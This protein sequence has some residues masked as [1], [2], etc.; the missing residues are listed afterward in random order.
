MIS[1][2]IPCY[3]DQ[4]VLPRAVRSALRQR[5]RGKLEVVI[6]DD[7]SK[8]PVRNDF[9]DARVRLV[10]HDT[11]L[12]LSNAINTGVANA[13]GDRFVVLAS[14]DELAPEYLSKV[15]NFDADI[16]SC[17][18]LSGGR[19]VR[20]GAPPSLEALMERNYHSYAALIKRRVWEATGGFKAAMNPS[21]EDWEFFLNAYKTGARW[22]HVSE[23]LHIY[24]RNQ[25]GRDAMAQGKDKLL[26]GKLMGYHQDIYGLGRGVVAFVIP[27]YRHEAY[28]A[29][30]AR[31]ALGQVYPHVRVVV[32]DDGSPGD[33]QGALSDIEDDRLVLIRQE[34]RHLSGARNSGITYA[35]QTWNPEY[36]VMLDADDMVHSDYLEV[37]LGAYRDH[38]YIYTDVEFRG[39]A[40]H[41]VDMEEYDCTRLA[42]KHLH[43]CTFLQPAQMWRDI[44]AA[45]GYGYD[46]YMKQGYEDWEYAIAALST[47]W[48]GRRVP[49]YYF[50]YRYHAGGSMRTEA[51]KV[52]DALVNYI[53]KQHPWLTNKEYI[54]A[55]C[56]SCG[57]GHGR[58][59][60]SSSV[61]GGGSV[62]INGV[63][64]VA[65]GEIL[66]VTYN[67][68]KTSTMQKIGAGGQIYRYSADPTKQAKGYGPRFTIYARDAHLFVGQFTIR[69]LSASPTIGSEQQPPV[70][71]SRPVEVVEIRPAKVPEQKTAQQIADAKPKKL[72]EM[73]V[74][75]ALE[76][77]DA[78]TE[79]PP[80]DFSVLRGVGRAGHDKLVRAGFTVYDD[81]AE[82]SSTEL[83][84]ILGVD[85]KKAESIKRAAAKMIEE[86]S[87][88][89]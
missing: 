83:A 88:G 82:A 60:T 89:E 69:R 85:V 1:I 81:V 77:T 6:V 38:E 46:E 41:R 3:N 34:N 53:N 9:G 50:Y 65:P 63:G 29:D 66:Q 4:D 42:K 22:V 49:G 68:S 84:A 76:L 72:D 80:E 52:R 28:V 75:E 32:V 16:V 62:Y 37:T 67:G 21:W 87:E 2:I 70:Q 56:R 19:H 64:E 5:Y 35:L 8:E 78:G 45:R 23:P 55:A 36:L 44:V 30:A 31:S 39:D 61:R 74:E 24:H 59:T 48:C 33:V 25:S 15:A 86:L 73:P 79:L 14:D 58:F 47:G 17:D 10:R 7:G 26:W 57:G 51:G 43:P 40:Y 11:N 18:M 27:C 12:G 54:M 13:G 71:T 20:A